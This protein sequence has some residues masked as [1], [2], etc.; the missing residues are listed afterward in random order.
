LYVASNNLPLCENGE[1]P[2]LNIASKY[3]NQPKHQDVLFSIQALV[4]EKLQ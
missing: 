3:L 2:T 4:Q 1:E